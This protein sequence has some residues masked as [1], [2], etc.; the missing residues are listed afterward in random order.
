M[1]ERLGCTGPCG[2][3]VEFGCGYGTFTIPAAKYATGRVYAFDIEPDMVAH[4]LG[5]AQEAGLSKVV[6]IVRDFVTDDTGLPDATAGRAMLFNILH[7]ERPLTLLREAYRVLTPGGEVGIIHWR[8]DIETPRGPSL[9]I[10]PTAERCREWAEQV[11][12][13]FI[14]QE[15]LNCCSWHWGLVMRRP[16]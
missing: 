1:V 2:D 3:V 16:L 4:T 10:R 14:R 8:R 9:G 12:F 7:I 6:G 11:G 5:K 13:E 15:P